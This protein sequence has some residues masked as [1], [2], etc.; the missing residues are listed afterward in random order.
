MVGRVPA[1]LMARSGFTGDHGRLTAVP[2]AGARTRRPVRL[3]DA[4]GADLVLRD[5][6]DR[7]LGGDRQ[8]VDA[9]RAG[10]VI[11]HEDRVRPDRRH[12]LRPQGELAPAR[13]DRRPVA[14][15]DAEPVRQPRV[16][17]DARLRVLIDQRPDAPRLRA[18]EEL[19]DHAPGRQDHRVL[20]VDVLGRRR[21]GGDVEAGLAVGEVE[22]A[23]CPWRPGSTSPARTA[24]ACRGGPRLGQGQK[25]PICCS[26]FS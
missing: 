5:L 9:L 7:V 17:L 8:P 2:P 12:H 18:R 4:D 26:I 22:A 6:R 11:G 25:T 16:D 20:G 10:P 19:A 14:V 24:A 23:R 1:S 3:L 15:G 21:V 13:F